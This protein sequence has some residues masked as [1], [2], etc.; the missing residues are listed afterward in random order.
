[1]VL[2]DEA[3]AP[4]DPCPSPMPFKLIDEPHLDL[5][6]DEDNVH[7]GIPPSSPV[8]R[9]FDQ[10][11]EG[12]E[13]LGLVSEEP[14]LVALPMTPVALVVNLLTSSFTPTVVY[15]TASVAI[16]RE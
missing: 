1:M 10:G 3:P 11:F 15:I 12:E 7:S 2:D 4:Q 5:S 16:P 6:D 14:S 8:E 9:L 13:D